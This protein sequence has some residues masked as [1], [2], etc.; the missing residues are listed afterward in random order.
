MAKKSIQ[1]MSDI[2]QIINFSLSQ[3]AFAEITGLDTDVITKLLTNNV[4]QKEITG[5]LLFGKC[6]RQ[7]IQ[8]YKRNFVPTKDNSP[9]PETNDRAIKTK[10]ENKKL[11][12]TIEAI[13]MKNIAKR[14]AIKIDAY[15]EIKESLATQLNLLKDAM[16]TLEN[17]AINTAI[18][19]ALLALSNINSE[20]AIASEEGI[21]DLINEK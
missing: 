9:T 4:I 10:L 7:I 12:A 1:Y 14:N 8:H 19:N 5:D 2:A 15:N 18:D 11:E 17:K 21:E 20:E 16:G 3:N 6:I 13:E